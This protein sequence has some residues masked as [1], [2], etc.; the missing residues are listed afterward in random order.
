MVQKMNRILTFASIAAT[1][2]LAASVSAQAAPA[3]VKVGTL[4][5]HEH[6]GWGY[7]VGSSHRVRCVYT[8]FAGTMRY[9]GR[10]SKVGVDIGYQHSTNILWTVVAPTPEL[11]PGDLSGHYGGVTASAAVGLGVGANA[12]VGGSARSIALQ[13]VSVQ[14]STG[15]DVAAGVG[16]LS[17]HAVPGSFRP[18]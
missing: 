13:P 16:T 6:P 12:L 18:A 10:I 17:L 5:C 7:V 4:S 15:L 11:R 3:G 14:G 9:D 2:G 1:V 8:G